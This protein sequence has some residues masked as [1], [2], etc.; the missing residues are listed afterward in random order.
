M[1]QIRIPRWYLGVEFNGPAEI[2]ILFSAMLAQMPLTTADLASQMGVNQSTIS[3]WGTGGA[4]P[5]L[6]DMVRASEILAAEMERLNQFAEEVSEA[7]KI[8]NQLSESL[9]E[10][11]TPSRRKQRTAWLADLDGHIARGM[12]LIGKERLEEQF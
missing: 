6:K 4:S 1:S 11:R 9:H 2:A 12:K 5:S 3:R 7:V 8:V 10:K